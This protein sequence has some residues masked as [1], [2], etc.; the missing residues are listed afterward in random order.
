MKFT[1]NSQPGAAAAPQPAAYA[2]PS[3]KDP[4]ESPWD[5][6][7]TVPT[8]PP[9]ATPPTEP[10]ED[11]VTVEATP[12]EHLFPTDPTV[13]RAASAAA[14]ETATWLGIYR[15]PPSVSEAWAMSSS[16]N[17]AKV[18]AESG[19]LAGVWWVINRSERLV[20]F[21]AILVL[22]VVVSTLLWCACR[23]SRRWGL[24]VVVIVVFVVVPAITG[25]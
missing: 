25:G 17:R 22:L 13:G 19:L 7:T 4:V 9:P 11:D 3:G 10:A 5:T 16:L 12:E 6:E 20:I 2:P 18:P 15:Q 8:D 14:H 21:A 24:Y 1:T 23:P